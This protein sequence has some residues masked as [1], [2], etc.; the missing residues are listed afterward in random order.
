MTNFC[1]GVQYPRNKSDTI[2]NIRLAPLARSMKGVLILFVDPAADGEGADYSRDSEKFYNPKIKKVSVTL[3]AVLQR[4]AS[5][6]A[7]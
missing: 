4:H 1:Y 3:W 7:F 6:S 2:W 5:S